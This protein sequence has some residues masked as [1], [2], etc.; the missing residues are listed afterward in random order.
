M[1]QQVPRF[2]CISRRARHSA[3]V[4]RGVNKVG[5]VGNEITV[6][7]VILGRLGGLGGE[8][9]GWHYKHRNHLTYPH[10]TFLD[11]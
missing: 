6:M 11:P 4:S 1:G 2:P 5:V 8:V 9:P 7:Q 10:C 3:P